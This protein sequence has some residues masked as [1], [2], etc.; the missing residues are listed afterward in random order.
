MLRNHVGGRKMLAFLRLFF[1]LFQSSALDPVFLVYHDPQ[2]GSG[3]AAFVPNSTSEAIM[4]LVFSYFTKKRKSWTLMDQ[5]WML[6]HLD[7]WYSVKISRSTLNYNLAILRREGI[8]ETVLRHKR[9][10]SGGFLP[11]VTLYKM[12]KRLAKF[13]STVAAWFK[14]CGWLPSVKMLR[15][16][17]VPVVGRATTREEVS[18]EYQKARCRGS[19]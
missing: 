5:N 17:F 19:G 11:Q 13:Y 1:S 4:R 14:R 16:G 3:D 9:D 2:A 8:I 12:T 10:S 15:M 6:E 7:K 18:R